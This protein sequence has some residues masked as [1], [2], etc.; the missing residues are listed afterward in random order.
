MIRR[1]TFHEA[2][3]AEYGDA[4][5]AWKRSEKAFADVTAAYLTAKRDRDEKWDAVWDARTTVSKLASERDETSRAEL[6]AMNG[7][8]APV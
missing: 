5:E 1:P 7:E 3:A 4:H 8:L 6:S 2:A